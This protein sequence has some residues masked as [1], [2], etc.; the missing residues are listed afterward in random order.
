MN[1]IFLNQTGY[2]PNAKKQAS[3]LNPG[4][5]TVI[6]ENNDTVFEGV[7]SEFGFDEASGDNVY[8]ADFSALTQ[9][10]KYCIKDS[11][12]EKSYT[13]D[14]DCNIYEPL[15]KDLIRAF[16]YQRC[17]CALDEKHAGI[18]KHGLCHAGITKIFDNPSQTKDMSGGWHDAGDFGRYVTPGAVTLGHLLYAYKMFPSSFDMDLNIPESGNNVPDILN[19]CRY[20]LEW[21]LKCQREDGAVYHKVTTLHH[22]PFVMPEDDLKDLYAYPVSSMAAGDFAAIM[23][24]GYRMYEKYDEAFAEK[25]LAA[26]KKTYEWLISNPEFTG[27]T[28]PEGT[29]TGDYR[30]WSDKDERMWAATELF[31]ATGENRYLS[32]MRELV[33]E[34]IPLTQFGWAEV[35]GFASLCAL[36]DTAKQVPED[37]I[38]LFKERILT[39]ATRL[40]NCSNESGYGVAMQA[41]DFHW[42]SNGAIGTR[43]MLLIIAGWLLNDSSYYELAANQ[44]NYIL[45][46]NALGYSY[47]TG[48]GEHAFM[49]PHNRPTQADKIDLPMPGWVSGG[50]NGHPCDEVASHVIKEGTPPMKCYVDDW[51]SFSTNEVAIYWNSPFVYIIGALISK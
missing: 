44:I 47:V 39:E 36:T 12:G 7:T 51:K 50:P 38:S 31:V 48:Y 41:R 17:G 30:D 45:G 9:N 35:S 43:G 21:I 42:G 15:L 20:E 13:F 25:M 2:L 4:K 27:F 24:L 10:G 19:E 14:I 8:I 33:K 46:R 28:N 18:Y 6:N 32:D 37:L 5:F 3:L 16:Y 34:N 40:A 11:K 23:A 1:N 49:H 26:S 29:G 22:A